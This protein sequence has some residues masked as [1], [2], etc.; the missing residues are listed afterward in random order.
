MIRR[1]P[2]STLFP[3]RRSS[4]LAVV[5]EITRLQHPDAM[6]LFAAVDED[7]RRQFR[8]EA[9][10]AGV[11]VG[12]IARDPELHLQAFAALKARARSSM[13]SSG[14]SS[15]IDRRIVPGPIPASASAASLMRK[16]VVLAGW[17]SEER[18]VGKE[19][20]S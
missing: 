4:D 18:R 10:P 20:R 2:R 8:V 13:R 5:R 6:V 14:S 16:C 12:G 9:L 1:P 11:G 15:P 3:T 19:C 17:R 7:D